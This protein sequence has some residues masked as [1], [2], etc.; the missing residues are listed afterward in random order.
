[1]KRITERDLQAETRRTQL[2][3]VAL[4][5]FAENGVE[6]VS[7]KD[8]ATEAR[9]AQGLV[10]HYF[11]SKDALLAAVLRRHT[12]LPAFEAV[13]RDM[14]PLSAR[15]GLLLFANRMAVLLPEKRLILRLVLRE[16]LSPR[17]AMLPQALAFH[18]D[19]TAQLATFFEK[20]IEAGEL[21]P[22]QPLTS[23]HMLM[24]SFLMLLILD[25]PLQPYVS[26]FVDTILSGIQAE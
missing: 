15:D 13:V 3:D 26:P 6:N 7:M 22:H 23:V 19:V 9:V 24:S 8:L 14:M 18:D 21:R 11:E 20:R 2:V 16:V 4:R 5:L 10:Y 25:Q 12:P 17:S 1:M